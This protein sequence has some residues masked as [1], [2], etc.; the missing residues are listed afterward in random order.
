[1]KAGPEEGVG[2]LAAWAEFEDDG[3]PLFDD[4]LLNQIPTDGVVDLL[5]E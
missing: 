2:E 1:M 5:G 4:P 3:A